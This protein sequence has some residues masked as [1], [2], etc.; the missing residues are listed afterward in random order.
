MG[1]KSFES[2]RAR[3]KQEPLEFDFGGSAFTVELPIPSI[4]I[5]EMANEDEAKAA[6]AFGSFLQELL[7]PEQYKTFS[8]ICR[9]DRTDLAT[10]A[11]IVGW[12]VEEATGRP[13]AQQSASAGG[14]S[15][16]TQLSP[17]AATSQD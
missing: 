3:V 14:S 1:R 5:L 12:I 6:V 9:R 10:M 16:D 11:E 8:G 17:G 2:A 15:T 13:T 7:G 4:S